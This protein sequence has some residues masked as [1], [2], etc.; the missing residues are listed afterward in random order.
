MTGVAM[1]PRG[2]DIVP[3]GKTLDQ[4]AE[5]AADERGNQDGEQP[6]RQRA[7]PLVAISSYVCRRN[8]V[9]E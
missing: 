7:L 9:M 5:K 6:V 3:I 1:R 8:G 2:D 4:D